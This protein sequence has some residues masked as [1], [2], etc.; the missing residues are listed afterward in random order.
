[1]DVGLFLEGFVTVAGGPAKITVVIATPGPPYGFRAYSGLED[2]PP[3]VIKGL[4]GAIVYLP[5][6]VEV[7]SPLACL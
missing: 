4:V 7:S 5:I 6:G 2:W 3:D 1:M